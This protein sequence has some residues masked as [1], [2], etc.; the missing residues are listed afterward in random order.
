[1]ALQDEIAMLVKRIAD[2]GRLHVVALGGAFPVNFGMCPVDVMGESQILPGVLSFLRLFAAN[3]NKMHAK[4][5]S[6]FELL[7]SSR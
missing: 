3:T 5:V 6:V 2:D 1:M 4:A 7:T